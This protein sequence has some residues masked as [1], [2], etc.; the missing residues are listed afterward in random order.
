MNAM[1]LRRGAGMDRR[2]TW[3][4]NRRENRAHGPDLRFARLH[5]AFEI[6]EQSP[7]VAE[8]HPVNDNQKQL[9]LTGQVVPPQIWAG[10]IIPWRKLNLFSWPACKRS[11]AGRIFAELSRCHGLVG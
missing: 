9:R 8:R 7:P 10:S 2:V 1:Y 4:R 3:C 5:P 6:A 11:D